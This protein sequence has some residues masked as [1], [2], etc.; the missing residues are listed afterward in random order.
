MSNEETVVEII[1]VRVE[2]K[3]RDVVFNF[4]TNKRRSAELRLSPDVI[5]PIAVTLF[6]LGQ[7]ILSHDSEGVSGQVMVLAGAIPA[8]G[9]DRQPVLDL[10]LS[11]GLH[12]P[13]T[14]P[15]TMIEI[16]HKA[17]ATL[18]HTSIDKPAGS[19]KLN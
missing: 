5:A 13:V 7:K 4:K 18:H 14:F 6:G 15:E 11:G 1:G 16:F 9:P 17:F 10:V 19:E 3:T 2:S 12:F 8:R